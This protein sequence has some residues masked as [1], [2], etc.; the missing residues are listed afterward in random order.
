MLG[1]RLLVGTVEENVRYFVVL[2][3]VLILR[4]CLCVFGNHAYILPIFFFH[5]W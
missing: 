2:R 3:I 5:L 1:F 4:R